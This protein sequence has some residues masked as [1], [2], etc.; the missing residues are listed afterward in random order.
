MTFKNPKC[1]V[2]TIGIREEK[3]ITLW[4]LSM[5]DEVQFTE[6]IIS[7]VN[8]YNALNSLPPIV[9]EKLPENPSS[10]DILA[11]MKD[12]L[13][14]PPTESEIAEYILIQIKENLVNL[15]KFICDEE[16]TLADMDNEQFVE[17]CDLIY[18]MN[19]A[20]AMGKFKALVM[21]AKTLFPQMMPSPNSSL[22]PATDTSTSTDSATEKAE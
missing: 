11:A 21:K 16:I 8:G 19:F 10:E 17:I 1:R 14:Q 6:T 18:E 3:K 22:T 5:A 20:G 4:P 13:W 7:A 12:N 15:L 9:T 2:I